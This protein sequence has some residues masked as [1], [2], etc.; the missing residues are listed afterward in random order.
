V[1]AIKSHFLD[2]PNIPDHG[3][4]TMILFYAGHGNRIATMNNIISTDGKVEA[5]APVDEG[6]TDAHGNYVYAI[7]DYVLG[8]LLREI[9]EKKG[10]NMVRC[11]FHPESDSCSHLRPHRP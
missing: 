1:S 7:P 3:K 10:P 5:I 8:W 11:L 6:T 4:A 9:S 2:N